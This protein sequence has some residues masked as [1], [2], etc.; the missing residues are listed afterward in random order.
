MNETLPQLPGSVALDLAHKSLLDEL[1]VR[2]PPRAS[3]MTFTNLW[4]W[5][6]THPVRLA[7]WRDTVVLW[8]GPTQQGI[9]LPPLGPL[10]DEGLKQAAVWAQSLG[11]TPVFGRLTEDVVAQLQAV[12]PAWRESE[13]RDNADYVYVRQ[14]LADLTGRHLD[15]KRNLVK[16]FWKAAAAEY[17]PIDAALAREC[18]FMQDFWCDVRLCDEN[19]HLADE[20]LSVKRTLDH[21]SELH[22]L[23]GALV[24]GDKV[25]GFAIGEQLAPGVAVVHYEKADG[26]YPGIY[27]ALNQEFC[28]QALVGFEF[29][30][31]EQDLG[32]EGLRKAKLSYHP[33]HLEMKYRLTLE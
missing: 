5:G 11:G 18:S 13:D 12:G 9:L 23:G 21:W 19:P 28:R 4:A 8:R 3:E 33:H 1:L 10:D 26:S 27:Q 2:R 15:G 7:A 17:R 31:R 32:V 29:V 14:E 16:K 22:L 30:N 25:L 20:N 24:L 6:Q